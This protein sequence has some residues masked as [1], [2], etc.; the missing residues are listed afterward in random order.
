M[1]YNIANIAGA[2]SQ[3]DADNQRANLSDLQMRQ[4]E[5]SLQQGQANLKQ[6][7]F[8]QSQQEALRAAMGAAQGADG[9]FNEK[10][11]I[12]ILSKSAPELIPKLQEQ[13]RTQSSQITSDKKEKIIVLGKS[14]S[15]IIRSNGQGYEQWKAEAERMFPGVKLPD[16]FDPKALQSFVDQSSALGPTTKL[17]EGEA[18]F[19]VNRNLVN[20]GPPGIKAETLAETKRLNDAKIANMGGDSKDSGFKNSKD[21]RQEFIG[22]SKDFKQIS[23]AFGRIQAA[24]KNPSAAGDLALI[25][26]YMKL[27][28]PGSTVREG[29]FATAQNSAG[30]PERVRAMYNNA[31]KGERLTEQTRQ[32]FLGRADSLYKS[33]EQGQ[34][35]IENVYRGLAE[36][37]ELDPTNVLVDYRVKRPTEPDTP[38]TPFTK[39]KV[40]PSQKPKNQVVEVDW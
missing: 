28:D 7:Q 11:A 25:F 27:L 31:T 37:A 2:V 40:V 22:Q 32:D 39:K 20:I 14:A 23:D 8:T 15:P 12:D 30:I 29:E 24:G 19:D 9:S 33:Q 3:A 4:G 6:S 35:Q 10:A 36:R 26:N 38:L 17:S 18:E 5:V 13:S 1:G 21:L 34:G 16:T